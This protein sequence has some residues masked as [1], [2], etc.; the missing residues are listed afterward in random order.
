MSPSN[1]A[2]E[3]DT[4]VVGPDFDGKDDAADGRT[5]PE[6]VPAPRSAVTAGAPGIA[7]GG[8]EMDLVAWLVAGNVALADRDAIVEAVD[9]DEGARCVGCCGNKF[10][11]TVEGPL[12]C[13]TDVCVGPDAVRLVVRSL[14]LRARSLAFAA[15]DAAAAPLFADGTRWLFRGPWRCREAMFIG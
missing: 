3:R 5:A 6:L 15:L 13:W 1:G 7:A 12:S 9:A 10:L 8:A 11:R 4:A 2:V 14:S